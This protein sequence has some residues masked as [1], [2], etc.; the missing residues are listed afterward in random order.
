MRAA[1]TQTPL[2]AGW[3]CWLVL[4][5]LGYAVLIVVLAT[6]VVPALWHGSGIA[7]P[8]A[9]LVLGVYLLQGWALWRWAGHAAELLPP[10]RPPGPLRAG[11]AGAD[12]GR[13]G[14]GMDGVE[15]MTRRQRATAPGS[16]PVVG[17]VAPGQPVSPAELHAVFA[18]PGLSFAAKGVLALVL[19]CPPGAVIGMAELFAQS[20]DPMS[21]VERAVTELVDGGLLT[22]TPPGRATDSS[23]GGVVFGRGRR[24]HRKGGG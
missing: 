19:S 5:V 24:A 14:P 18:D 3:R 15:P 10:A 22:T 23:A 16:T 4:L 13:R 8:A 21:Q 7:R 2:L 1:H 11:G 17:L 12:G 6:M 9:L 20:A